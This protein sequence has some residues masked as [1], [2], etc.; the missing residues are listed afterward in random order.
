VVLVIWVAG[1]TMANWRPFN[2]TGD[3]QAAANR[4][5][6]MSLVPFQDYY[7]QSEYNSFDQFL[8]KSL[9]FMPVGVLLALCLPHQHK[10][11]RVLALLV[12]LLL[13][14]VFEGGQFFLPS[15]FPSITDVL[16]ETVAT[17]IGFRLAGRALLVLSAS[18]KTASSRRSASIRESV[19]TPLR[20]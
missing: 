15:R 10:A 16:I 4:Y 1:L 3:F 8:M 2:F 14:G 7:S 18:A 12:G 17:W 9:T 20:M 13:A 11:A 5:Q 6:K 19:R